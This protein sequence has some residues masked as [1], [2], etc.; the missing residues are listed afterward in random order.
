MRAAGRTLVV[1]QSGGPTA[2]INAT[3][4]G[5]VESALASGSYDRVVGLRYGIDGL[6]A[7]NVIDLGRQSAA[8]LQAVRHTP[9]AALGTGRRKVKDGE[10]DEALARLRALDAGAFVYIGGNDSADTAHRLHRAAAA[11]GDPLRVI[12]AP[13]TIDND[14]PHTDHCPGYG[15]VARHLANAVRDAVYDTLAT[16]GLYPVKFVEVMGRDA[17]WVAAACALGFGAD[18]ADLQPLLFLP[19]RPVHA[20]EALAAVQAMQQA[21]GW[22]VA[23][24]PDALQEPG[25]GR[26]GAAEPIHVDAFGHPYYES[27]AALLTRLATEQLG[28]RARFD[29]PGTAARASMTVISPVDHEEAYAVGR[30]AAARAAAGESDLLVTI[31]RI[32]D[33]PYRSTT[34]AAPL[35]EVA[36]HVRQLPDGYIDA[37]GHGVTPAFRTWAMP[38]LGADPF[39]AYGRLAPLRVD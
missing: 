27:P 5:V 17:G 28:H 2:V 29:R 8:T 12:A 35:A 15:S 33:A 4:V 26:F 22:A 3:L 30:A 10:L 23:V 24:V 39:P 37:S 31:D 21:R 6:F 14:L 38:L 1:G 19:E 11:A 18:E 16:P 9:A 36:N 25:G 32:S 13:K 34:G 7:G 20:E